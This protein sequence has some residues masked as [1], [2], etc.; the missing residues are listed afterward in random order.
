MGSLETSGAY[1]VIK[2]GSFCIPASV[3]YK[4]GYYLL[5]NSFYSPPKNSSIFSLFSAAVL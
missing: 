5:Q 2:I 3:L 1:L 4:T